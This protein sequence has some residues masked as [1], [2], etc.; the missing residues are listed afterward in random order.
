M[1][2]G[3]LLTKTEYGLLLLTALFF[4]LLSALLY[5]GDDPGELADYTISTEQTAE[6]VTP[7]VLPPLNINSATAE[8]LEELNGIGPVLAQRII[9]YREEH[10]P[11]ADVEGLL[12]VKGIG[13]STLEQFRDEI[14]TKEEP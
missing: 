8:E 14:T 9:D 12:E 6:N 4:C 1:N 13:E 11:F 3:S 10:G 7:E 2:I 5:Y